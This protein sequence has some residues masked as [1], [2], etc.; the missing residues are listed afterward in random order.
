MGRL[1]IRRAS[2]RE[3]PAGELIGHHSGVHVVELRNRR[4]N[5]VGRAVV[6]QAMPTGGEPRRGSRMVSSVSLVGYCLGRKL[7]DG[8]AE[9]AVFA[10]DDI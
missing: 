1:T 5:P 3:P 9:A 2:L 7:K 8:P 6:E 4:G 10:F